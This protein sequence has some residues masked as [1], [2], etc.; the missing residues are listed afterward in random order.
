MNSA[1]LAVPHTLIAIICSNLLQLR[2]ARRTELI[3]EALGW[4]L[5]PIVLHAARQA[6]FFTNAKASDVSSLRSRSLWQIGGGIAILSLCRA[7]AEVVW[8]LVS[9]ICSPTSFTVLDSKT[10]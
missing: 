4:V 2:H 6:G 8:I 10:D 1:R 7:E 3:C 5:L 9:P